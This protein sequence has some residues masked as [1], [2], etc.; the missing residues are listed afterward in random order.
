MQ[1]W[2]IP[3]VLVTMTVIA[4]NVGRVSAE[5]RLLAGASDYRS[6]ANRVRWRLL[7]GVW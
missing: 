2:S 6:Y 3:N 5:E 4:C 1:S 7:P